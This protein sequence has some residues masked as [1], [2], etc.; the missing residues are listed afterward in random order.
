MNTLSIG[1]ASSFDVRGDA[2]SLGEML[3]TNFGET[4]DNAV[5]LPTTLQSMFDIEWHNKTLDIVAR[6]VGSHCSIMLRQMGGDVLLYDCGEF[7][8]CK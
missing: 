5:K 3:T 2:G 6:I 8:S 4:L 1:L 7:G